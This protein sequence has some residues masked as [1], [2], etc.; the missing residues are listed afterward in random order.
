MEGY[1]RDYRHGWPVRV[2]VCGIRGDGNPSECQIWQQR[3]DN[4]GQVVSVT[5]EPTIYHS[6]A[7]AANAARE[8]VDLYLKRFEGAREERLRELWRLTA[9]GSCGAPPKTSPGPV[10]FLEAILQ[11]QIELG[12]L[13]GKIRS[14]NEDIQ[15]AKNA[16]LRSK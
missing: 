7:A 12:D 2:A 5:K 1:H 4:T 14:T 9:A 13:P 16:L 11:E 3:R 8:H 10:P 6:E 15:A